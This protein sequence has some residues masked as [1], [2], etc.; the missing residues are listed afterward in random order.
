MVVELI[1]LCLQSAKVP[2][3]AKIGPSPLQQKTL[4]LTKG[5]IGLDMPET[6]QTLDENGSTILSSHCRSVFQSQTMSKVHNDDM[7]KTF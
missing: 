7:F 6:L 3:E 2:L 1:A 4:T 5:R